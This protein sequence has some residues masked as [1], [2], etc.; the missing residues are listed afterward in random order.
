MGNTRCVRT[1]DTQGVLRAAALPLTHRYHWPGHRPMQ[2]HV[3]VS[4]K[5]RGRHAHPQSQLQMPRGHWKPTP[6]NGGSLP[7]LLLVPHHVKLR[8]GGH[9]MG[10][11]SELRGWGG[12][13]VRRGSARQK[14]SQA[15]LASS[16]WCPAGGGCVRVM[17]GDSRARK[18]EPGER[19]PK[20]CCEPC[21]GSR[22]GSPGF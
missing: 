6:G 21:P 3:G 19:R 18:G 11:A 7:C 8:G 16:S 14:G 15:A 4:R 17:A 20:P 9:G 13:R 10:E 2:S 1:T 22:G 12:N 5:A